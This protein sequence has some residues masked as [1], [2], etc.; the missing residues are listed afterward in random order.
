MNNYGQLGDGTK[1]NRTSPVQIKTGTKFTQISAGNSH[2]LAIDDKGQLFGTGDVYCLG[3]SS[4][5]VL[6]PEKIN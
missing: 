4:L 6:I 2:S 5:L 1:T 3:D